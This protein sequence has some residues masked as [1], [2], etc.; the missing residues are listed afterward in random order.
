MAENVGGLGGSCIHTARDGYRNTKRVQTN[1]LL[2]F[3]GGLTQRLDGKSAMR[4]MVENVGRLAFSCICRAG[5]EQGKTK[6]VRK[7]SFRGFRGV[8]TQGIDGMW[9]RR[10]VWL[11]LCQLLPL[12]DFCEYD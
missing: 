2:A 8:L 4:G 1:S 9:G 7:N 12:K 10:P 3:G 11:R 5:K 6:Q